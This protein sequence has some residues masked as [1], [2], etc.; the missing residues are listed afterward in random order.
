MLAQ[1]ITP[2]KS[3]SQHRWRNQNTPG[4][5]QIQT[6]SIYQPSPKE[7]PGRKTPTKRRY[8]NQRKDKILS[9]SQQSQKQRAT[10]HK[11]TYK[12]QTYQESTVISL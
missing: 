8:L 11:A 1:A 4:Q 9:I 12:K 3:L 6:V 10:A 5:T 2:R 7:N